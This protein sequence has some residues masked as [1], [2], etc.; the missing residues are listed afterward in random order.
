MGLTWTW[1]LKSMTWTTWTLYLETLDSIQDN[2]VVNSWLTFK[3][4]T[5]EEVWY[6]AVSLYGAWRIEE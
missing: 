1:D 5:H 6:S 2:I 3:R 4:H